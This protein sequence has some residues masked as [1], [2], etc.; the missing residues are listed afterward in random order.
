MA[1]TYIR[2]TPHAI[3][4]FEELRGQGFEISEEAVIETMLNPVQIVKGHTD[5]TIA[6]APLS[7]HLLLRVVYDEVG[8]TVTVITFYPAER[9][10]YEDN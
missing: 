3:A 7:D 4:K 8:D 10:R 6:Q 9:S 1:P 2:F 5:R